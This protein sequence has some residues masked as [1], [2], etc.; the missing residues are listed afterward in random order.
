MPEIKLLS[1]VLFGR[2]AFCPVFQIFLSLLRKLVLGP[3]LVSS[4]YVLSLDWLVGLGCLR[5]SVC[6]SKKD[7]FLVLEVDRCLPMFFSPCEE[8]L[9][10]FSLR[11]MNLFEAPLANSREAASSRKAS[12]ACCC[13]S[14]SSLW[15]RDSLGRVTFLPGLPA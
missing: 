12:S 2:P 10:C 8:A 14:L 4:G 11:P 15:P 6:A 5:S 13:S 9:R 1:L 7:W 3:S